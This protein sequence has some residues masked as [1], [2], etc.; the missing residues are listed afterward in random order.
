MIKQRTLKRIVQAT[1]VGLHTGKKVTLTL[2]PAPANTGS[3]IV[4]PT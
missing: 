3:S 2:R 1:G 4:A